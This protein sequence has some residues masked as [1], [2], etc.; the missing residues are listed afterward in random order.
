MKPFEKMTIE[1]LW[2]DPYISKNMLKHHLSFQDDIAS[3]KLETIE[4]TVGFVIDK[5]GLNSE[6]KLCDFGCG[7]W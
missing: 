7:G 1:T 2:N 5:L 6:S 3:R 4:K